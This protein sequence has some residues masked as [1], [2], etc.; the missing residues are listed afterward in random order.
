MQTWIYDIHIRQL[1]DNLYHH[2]IFIDENN[3]DEE[4]KCFKKLCLD[5]LDNDFLP[6]K[7]EHTGW[8]L[9]Y[10]IGTLLI[11]VQIFLSNPDLSENS[12]LNLIKLKNYLNQ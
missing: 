1:F 11:Q 6:T 10:T 8:N 9:S 5:L 12:I 7:T 2:H 3:K 4:G